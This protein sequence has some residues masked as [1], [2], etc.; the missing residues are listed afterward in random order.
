[1]PVSVVKADNYCIRTVERSLAKGFELL[2]MDS[3][4][5]F[6]DLVK[7]GDT[8]FIKP[9]WCNSKYRTSC[10]KRGFLFS[11]ITHPSVI[12][13][14]AKKVDIALEGSGK[15]IIG[16]NPTIDANFDELM[17][18]QDLGSLKKSLQ[19]SVQILDL[20]P[21]VCDDLRYYG[22]KD[23]M[24]AQRGD[25]RGYSNIQL[26][27]Q[28]QFYGKEFKRF[29]G[30]FDDAKKETMQLHSGR[31]HCYNVCR[32]I[33]HSDVFI[34]IPKLKTHH[35]AGVTLNLK[36]L[37]GIVGNKNCLVHWRDGFPGIGGDAYPNMLSWIRD[38]FR[39]VKHR[40]GWHGNDTIWRMIV[41]L[42]TCM[43]IWHDKMFTVIDGILGG[44]GDGPFCVTSKHAKVLI[45]GDNLLEADI[46]AGQLMGFDVEK[47][48]HLNH[49][50]ETG[51][52]ARKR[53]NVSIS[54][55]DIFNFFKYPKGW[56]CL[57]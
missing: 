48:Q 21:I 29:H 9:N 5:P 39:K 50:L 14:V 17:T 6:K 31:N 32:S 51:E 4:N 52:I 22:R 10:P 45:M 36:G 1:M 54:D 7:P 8:V 24:R 49:Y 40:G 20:R 12:R 27:N 18:V 28:S 13:A 38:K 16:D 57:V 44:E 15:I 33:I 26:G 37:V 56:E 23:K 35:K 55:F 43:Q 53:I 34:S 25:P 47:I 19:A 46:I 42:Y 2:G 11:T 3:E 30:V 41:D